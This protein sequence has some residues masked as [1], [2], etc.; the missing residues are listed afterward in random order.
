MDGSTAVD[1]TT[2]V[3]T[4]T[5]NENYFGDDSFDYEVCDTGIPI[6]CDSAT[7][8]I[9]VIP[10]Q[11][12]PDAVDD[13]NATDED[14]LLS[15]SAPGVLDND[16][17][18]DPDDMLTV[19]GSD[20]S[21]ADGA[22][23]SVNADGSYIYDPTAAPVLQALASGAQKVDT[24]VYTIGDGHGNQDS[25]TVS[26]LVTGVNDAPIANDDTA[27][28]TLNTAVNIN[29]VANDSD[30][31]GVLDLE[32]LSIISGPSHGSLGL[33]L[34]SGQ[35][36]Y[37]PGLSFWGFDSFVYQLCDDGDPVLCDTATVTVTGTIYTLYHPAVPRNIP[38]ICIT[39]N[40][41]P[42]S[43]EGQ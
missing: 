23:V 11:D 19:I 41:T 8:F 30:I 16:T 13:S 35:I 36:T 14:T 40:C 38:N 20:A 3:V 12:L 5:P 43:A 27:V 39:P 2:G 33:V 21:S 24:F 22:V 31:D 9:T 6:F 1:D 34:G 28:T 4:Y 37:D 25:A 42:F 29:V 26:I 17:D 7:V 32:T 10:V 18:P 15:V